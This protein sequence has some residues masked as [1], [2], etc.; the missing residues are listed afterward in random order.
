MKNKF[1]KGQ[2]LKC[3]RSG[4][5]IEVVAVHSFKNTETGK[6]EIFCSY[7]WCDFGL[8]GTDLVENIER[9]YELF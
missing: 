9:D 7:F 3:N 4:R 6:E 5:W 2:K 1:E 8:I